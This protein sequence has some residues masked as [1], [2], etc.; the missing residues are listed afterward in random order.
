[1]RPRLRAHRGEALGPRRAH[2]AHFRRPA[3]LTTMCARTKDESLAVLDDGTTA[4][5]KRLETLARRGAGGADV[6]PQVRRI[7]EAVRSGG[8]RA[9]L[10]FTEKFDRVR[11]RA[12]DLVVSDTE[13]QRAVAS[14]P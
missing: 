11:Q 4:A 3:V 5:E 14:V 9:L 6:E 12:R 13:I 1:P 8:D 7:L 10:D 2:P